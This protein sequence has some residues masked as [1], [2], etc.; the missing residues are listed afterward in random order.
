MKRED[1]FRQIEMERDYQNA[2]WG[3]DF[4]NLN[5]PNDW[6]SYIAKYLGNAVTMP[7][8][9][10]AFRRALLKVATLCVAA[11]ERE[12]YPPRHYDGQERVQ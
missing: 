10:E 1:I 11:L 3:E 8:N 6:V 7:W 4:D 12:N 9:A 5:T 2:R